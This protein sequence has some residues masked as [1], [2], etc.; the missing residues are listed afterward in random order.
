MALLSATPV[1]AAPVR[2]VKTVHL[3]INP[4]LLWTPTR[5]AVHKGDTI[6]ISA[7]GRMY[8]GSRPIDN[9]LPSGIAPGRQC[10]RA[11]ARQRKTAGGFPAPGLNCW[12]LI[13][14]IGASSPPFPIGSGVTRTA[15]RTGE[16]D[17]GVNDNYIGDNKNPW[18]VTVRVAPP[19]PASTAPAAK[20]SS[21]SSSLVLILAGLGALVV[22]L[23]LLLLWRR[24]RKSKADKPEPAVPVRAA[25]PATAAVAGVDGSPAGQ[26]GAL[27]SQTEGELSAGNIVAVTFADP[28]SLHVGYN[29]FPEHTEVHVRVMQGATPTT[30][31]FVTD[32]RRDATAHVAVVPLD[33][34]VDPE[35][36]AADVTFA[37]TVGGVPFNYAVRRKPGADPDAEPVSPT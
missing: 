5:L 24:S 8:F 27:Q 12:S 4:E 22:L 7:S 33:P 10:A 14:R 26:S 36:D 19:P 30:G 20:S 35:G 1:S 17:V 11:N 21:S 32:G 34:G 6:T 23:L 28:G 37:W 29:H 13:G 18:R 15:D 9:M 31:D 25:A 2:A 16:L 3:Q